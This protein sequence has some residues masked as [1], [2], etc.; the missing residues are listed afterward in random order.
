MNANVYV[1]VS[2]SIPACGIAAW[3]DVVAVSDGSTTVHLYSL[4][5]GLAGLRFLRFLRRKGWFPCRLAFL[6][7]S[8]PPLIAVNRREDDDGFWVDLT[9]AVSG[10]CLGVVG[11][12]DD[13]PK[14]FVPCVA[15]SKD[16]VAVT[17]VSA[18]GA[19]HGI[20][21]FC[22]ESDEFSSSSWVKARVFNA[23]MA[24]VAARGGLT[25]P[26]GLR[27]SPCGTYVV[28]CNSRYHDTTVDRYFVG[29]GTYLGRLY[30]QTGYKDL[31]DVQWLNRDSCEVAFVL[32]LLSDTLSIVESVQH[33][34]RH[35]VLWDATV[36]LAATR[37]ILLGLQYNNG[38]HAKVHMSLSGND[39]HARS[40]EESAMEAMS[41]D[42]VA[43][44]SVVARSFFFCVLHTI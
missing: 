44:M 36:A 35:A 22:R 23:E 32:Q 5:P 2:R 40:A 6:E 26:R 14:D 41:P 28:V 31:V 7:G 11:R 43:W 3:E 33:D 34:P 20:M 27:F 9:D 29:D 4:A 12:V 16:L 19:G 24:A 1:P 15:G 18:T 37:D 8:Q 25:A 21:M 38:V 10:A 13:V 17:Y 39:Y 30:G 42:R